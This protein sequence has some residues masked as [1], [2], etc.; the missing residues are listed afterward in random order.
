[1]DM[2]NVKE[3]AFLP[4]HLL[5]GILGL[6]VIGIGLVSLFMPVLAQ[7]QDAAVE[8]DIAWMTQNAAILGLSPEAAASETAFMATWNARRANEQATRDARPT[9][10]AYGRHVA[11]LN[12]TRTVWAPF[13]QATSAAWELT[14][15]VT[16][17][18]QTAT[19]QARGPMWQVENDPLVKIADILQQDMVE[20]SSPILADTPIPPTEDWD[21]ATP[22]LI[23]ENYGP[24]INPPPIEDPLGYYASGVV[25][26]TRQEI[27]ADCYAFYQCSSDR[28]D[29][30]CTGEN[31]AYDQCIAQDGYP[32]YKH[33]IQHFIAATA[34][35]EVT[36]TAAR[37]T[38]EQRD[39]DRKR[40]DDENNERLRNPQPRS[41]PTVDPYSGPWSRS[42]ATWGLN[43]A[44]REQGGENMG[45]EKRQW[46]LTC[47]G[48]PCDITPCLF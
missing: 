34:N 5:W 11:Q 37:A 43:I 26:N 32:V 9:T 19:W 16:S 13:Q 28:G 8:T 35:A 10:E 22:W 17:Q 23:D 47:V 21:N 2:N 14:V 15:A 24:P 33:F 41:Q 25:G 45:V 38:Q 3:K 36:A 18:A 29:F 30:H 7:P 4:T 20:Q 40:K 1:M 46:R 48:D 27:I 12:L 42:C 6:L 44:R 31:S 39:R